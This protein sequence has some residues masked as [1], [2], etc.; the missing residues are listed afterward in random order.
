MEKEITIDLKTGEPFK[1]DT[2]KI[3]VYRGR[4]IGEAFY[5]AYMNFIKDPENEKFIEQKAEEL[6]ERERKEREAKNEEV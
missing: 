4:K 6:R 1:I 2:S 3:S 5:N